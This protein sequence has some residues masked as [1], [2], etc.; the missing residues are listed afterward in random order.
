MGA[1]QKQGIQNTIISYA[2]ILIGFV[3][4]LVL[5]PIML[6]PEELGLTRILYSV[7]ILFATIFPIGLNSTTLKFFP[8]FKKPEKGNHGYLSLLILVSV[9]SYTLCGLIIF[10]CKE[11]ILE[12]YSNS[13]LFVQ[14]FRYVFPMS[15][16]L[17]YISLFN[18]YSFAL[19]KTTTPVF[20][21]EVFIRVCNTI[22][23]SIYFLKLISFEWFMRLFILSYFIQLFFLFVY[24]MKSDK[25]LFRIDWSFLKSVGVRKIVHYALWMAIGT[26]ASI[27]LRNVDIILLGSNLS[28]AGKSLDMVAVYSIA[29][30]IAGIIEAPVNALSRIGDS[31]ISDAFSRNDR[32]LIETV[33]YKSTKLLTLVGGLFFVGVVAN[34]HALLELLP[35][36]YHGSETVVII[37]G[38]SAFFNMVTGLNTSI[39]YYSEKY[40]LGNYLLIVLVIISVILNVILIPVYGIIGAA[41]ATGLALFLYNLLKYLYIW[42]VFKMQPFDSSI[43]KIFGIMILCGVVNY[44]LPVSSN[45]IVSILVRSSVI[46]LVYASAVYLMNIVPEFHQYIPFIG[47]KK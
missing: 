2:G 43:L 30:T 29:I 6:K 19:F 1:I 40:V 47:K 34:V 35:E 21:N 15:F 44:F 46:T 9:I 16:F 3:N 18:V 23:V 12:H 11:T 10:F 32:Q 31:K 8:V 14:Y 22:V 42:K 27:A 5:Q 28:Q 13:P 25:I 41:V 36:K 37:I 20:L 24:I 7:S 33:Y 38:I 17:G 26:V 45:H 4:I 39:M